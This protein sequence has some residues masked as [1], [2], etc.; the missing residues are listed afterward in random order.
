VRTV[1]TKTHFLSAHEVLPINQR[2]HFRTRNRDS[3]SFIDSSLLNNDVRSELLKYVER[4]YENV[5]GHLK[6]IAR[7]L[8]NGDGVKKFAGRWNR[9]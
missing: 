3:M 8:V 5:A 7:R 9:G 1:Q 4:P 2:L 6:D